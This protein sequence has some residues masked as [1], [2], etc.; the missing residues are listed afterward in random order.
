MIIIVRERLTQFL[1]SGRQPGFCF[2]ILASHSHVAVSTHA[3]IL[4]H[5]ILLFSVAMGLGGHDV[6]EVLVKID[7]GFLETET[8][9]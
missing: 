1:S 4:S 3:H 6:H 8:L 5:K 2:E 9:N 7:P